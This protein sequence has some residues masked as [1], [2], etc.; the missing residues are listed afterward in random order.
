MR[1]VKNVFGNM[2]GYE[3][4]SIFSTVVETCNDVVENRSETFA[5]SPEG[6]GKLL[7]ALKIRG[8]RENLSFQRSDF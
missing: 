7:E 5:R 3:N 8:L 6:R 2:V 4:S 1:R